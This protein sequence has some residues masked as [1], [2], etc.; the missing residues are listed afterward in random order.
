MNLYN[1]HGESVDDVDL[2]VL[3]AYYDHS[4]KEVLDALHNIENRLNN[5][6]DIPIYSYCK[7]AYY[8]IVCHTILGFDYTSCKEKMVLNMNKH[9]KNIDAD[10][11]LL[12]IIYE[13][14]LEEEKKLFKEFKQSIQEAITTS[15]HAKLDFSYHPDDL[16]SLRHNIIQ[17]KAEMIT[18]HI[19]ISKFDLKKVVTMLFQCSPLQ[20]HHW[21]DILFA[22]YRNASKSDFLDADHLYMSELVEKIES[23][24]SEREKHMDRI[25][26]LQIRYLLSNLKEFVEK[27]S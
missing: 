15:T 26:L 17:N 19:F 16:E 23:V 25:A 3:F 22:I 24:L 13:H 10:I 21:R 5:S 9:G 4:E 14:E 1:K 11:L 18:G 8:L 2:S 20:L 27:L 12:D 6:E 7:L